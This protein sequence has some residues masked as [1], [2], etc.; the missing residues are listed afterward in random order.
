MRVALWPQ[1]IVMPLKSS[2]IPYQKL[3]RFYNQASHCDQWASSLVPFKKCTFC[4]FFAVIQ[5]RMDA[6]IDV[7][8]R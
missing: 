7:G 1:S 8:A 3:P 6:C 2:I 4:T 5:Y